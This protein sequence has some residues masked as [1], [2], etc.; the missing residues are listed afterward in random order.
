M[1]RKAFIAP[2]IVIVVL[3]FLSV[4]TLI[5][6]GG[7]MVVA[8]SELQG[9]SEIVALSAVSAIGKGESAVN[10][11][12]ERFLQLNHVSN[13]AYT[14]EIESASLSIT[15]TRVIPLML[16]GKKGLNS[17]KVSATSRAVSD[18]G[19]VRLVP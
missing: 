5:V 7:K 15:L 19:Q 1:S 12:I 16:S 14:V 6:D 2:F 11:N 8:H 9:I 18:R 10:A 4:L 3:L 17:Y 13:C